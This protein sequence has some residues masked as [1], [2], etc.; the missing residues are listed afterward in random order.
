MLVNQIK[1]KRLKWLEL[2]PN[3]HRVAAE[4]FGKAFHFVLAERHL[5]GLVWAIAFP[6]RN[7]VSGKSF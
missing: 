4:A 2:I 7:E 1:T 6:V 5:N 3:R